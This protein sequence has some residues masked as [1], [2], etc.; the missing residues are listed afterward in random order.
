MVI[1]NLAHKPKFIML[2]KTILLE[3]KAS[4][5]EKEY[6]KLSKLYKH[7]STYGTSNGTNFHIKILS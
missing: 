4:L 6:K 7:I 3:N 5:T 2:K 1:N